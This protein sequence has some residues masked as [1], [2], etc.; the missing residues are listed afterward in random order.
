MKT[1]FHLKLCTTLILC[2][3]ASLFTGC[4]DEIDPV[5]PGLY[6]TQVVSSQARPEGSII[7][8]LNDNVVIEFPPGAVEAPVDVDIKECGVGGD[9]DFLLNMITI[10]PMMRFE[11]P[12][13]VSL[14]YEGD[15]VCNEKS[16]EECDIVVCHWENERSYL[17]RF[18]YRNDVMVECIKC[19]IDPIAKT[20]SF[21]T[22]ETGLFGLSINKFEQ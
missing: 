14:K 22:M 18:N 17:N 3:L 5:M 15:L 21:M 6:D 9:C 1:K 11:V 4:Q 12:V 19:T 2:A 10:A 8:A 13:T 7:S 20:V 16:A